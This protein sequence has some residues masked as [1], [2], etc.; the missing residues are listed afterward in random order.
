MTHRRRPNDRLRTLLKEADWT[1]EAL[2][3]AVNTLGAEIGCPLRYDR[4]AVAHW[5]SGTRPRHPVP[6]LAAEA[7]SRRIGRPVTPEAAGFPVPWR[8]PAGE[9]P[10]TGFAALCRSD[11][12]TGSRLVLQQR[13][14]RVA[15]ARAPSPPALPEIPAQR[16]AA[17]RD[18]ASPGP[19]QAGAGGPE[20]AAL[21]DAARFFAASIDTH[22]GRHARSALSTYLADDVTPLLT[23]PRPSPSRREMLGAAARLAFLLGR[24]YEDG[25]LHGLA[26]RYYTYAHRLASEGGDRATWSLV[27]RAMSA[28]AQRLGHLSS[29]LQ[30]GDAAARAAQGLAPSQQ[31][32][33][34]AQFA[35]ILA[36]TGERRGALSALATA[37]RAAEHAACG[38]G[39]SP[40]D[41]YPR[42]A[43][44]FQTSQVLE[45]LGDLPGAIGALR[46]SAAERAEADVRGRT[47]THARFG[48]MLLRTGRL[49]E[50]CA[51]WRRFL[52]GR[53]RLRSG[54]AERALR[55]MRRALRPYRNRRCAA[56]LLALSVPLTEH[57]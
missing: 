5:L 43:L 30:M 48:Q 51:A 21:H 57:S 52:S 2:A 15:D 26:Q 53:E 29:A 47:L 42:A 40:F 49:D 20:L 4:T 3:R 33:V 16:P 28:Q 18:P 12:E 1:Q 11:A 23:A 35:V 10:V 17:D 6:Q 56:E 36:Q 37:E 34:Q 44:L 14:Y 31:S 24:M 55:E 8:E 41:T 27:I 19:P 25:Q 50:A 45:A 46:R 13:P 9:D 38:Q 39:G 7:L 22:G 32:Y 54:D